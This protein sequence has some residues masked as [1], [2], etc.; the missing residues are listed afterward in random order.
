MMPCN[1]ARCLLAQD[2]AVCSGVYCH[3]KDAL[4]L[5]WD[6]AACFCCT[7]TFLRT[8]CARSVP[9]SSHTCAT[10][11]C[12]GCVELESAEARAQLSMRLQKAASARL[13]RSSG[14]TR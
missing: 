12:R 4:E 13:S 8:S 10:P 2:H 3:N 14:H 6:V 7:F 1:C 11:A 5:A 9:L